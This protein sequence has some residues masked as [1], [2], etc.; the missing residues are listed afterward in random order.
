MAYSSEVGCFCVHFWFSLDESEG[1]FGHLVGCCVA[2]S[3]IVEAVAECL[4]SSAP[5]DDID[6]LRRT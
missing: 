1:F 6:L 5:C 2:H 3:P 4:S